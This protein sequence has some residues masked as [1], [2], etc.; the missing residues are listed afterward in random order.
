[1]Q[2]RKKSLQEVIVNVG[3]GFVISYLLWLYLVPVL[4]DIETRPT[5]G[6][7]ITFLYTIASIARGYIVRRCYNY[8]ERGKNE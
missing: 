3:T 2:T 4:F 5:Q 1:V 6:L 7:G 8:F